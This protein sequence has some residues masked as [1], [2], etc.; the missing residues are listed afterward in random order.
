MR[1]VVIM[2]L[3]AVLGEEVMEKLAAGPYGTGDPM[4]AGFSKKPTARKGT[5][6]YLEQSL[7][8]QQ[9][10]GRAQYVDPQAAKEP[11]PKETAVRQAEREV[12]T[13]QQMAAPPEKGTTRMINNKPYQ[14]NREGSRWVRAGVPS[15]LAANYPQIPTGTL[16][17][18]GQAGLKSESAPPP[19]KPGPVSFSSLAEQAKKDYGR[20]REG[21]AGLPAAAGKDITGTG[22]YEVAPKGTGIVNKG[23]LRKAS[24]AERLQLKDTQRSALAD[25]GIAAGEATGELTPSQV[26]KARNVERGVLP[27]LGQ[28]ASIWTMGAAPGLLRGAKS[29]VSPEARATLSRVNKTLNKVTPRAGANIQQV[30]PPHRV[31]NVTTKDIDTLRWNEAYPASIRADREMRDRVVKRLTREPHNVGTVVDPAAAQAEK[32]MGRAQAAQM[33]KRLQT[34]MQ[35]ARQAKIQERAW[36]DPKGREPARIRE[37]HNIYRGEHPKM[38]WARDKAKAQEQAARV[39]EYEAGV[40]ARKAKMKVPVETPPKAPVNTEAQEAARRLQAE[41]ESVVPGKTGP[42]K[43]P[44]PQAA[45]EPASKPAPEPASRPASEAAPK[46]VAEPAPK[47]QTTDE[48]LANQR[49][50]AANRGLT[51]EQLKRK[52]QARVDAESYVGARQRYSELR[53]GSRIEKPTWGQRIKQRTLHPRTDPASPEV[54]SQAKGE[55]QTARD[56]LRKHPFRARSGALWDAIPN[57]KSRIAK[58]LVRNTARAGVVAGGAEVVGTMRER[59]F[60]ANPEGKRSWGTRPLSTALHGVPVVG[61]TIGPWA[62]KALQGTSKSWAQAGKDLVQTRGSARKQKN[63]GMAAEPGPPGSGRGINEHIKPPTPHKGLTT[64]VGKGNV[65]ALAPGQEKQIAAFK[66]TPAP[67]AAPKYKPAPTNFAEVR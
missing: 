18:Q 24:P 1:P 51:E 2:R 41:A 65:S 64:V 33:R 20:V 16:A 60:G 31:G 21:L 10:K 3:K 17:A 62:Q 30:S 34:R 23:E 28:T 11:T 36:K 7:L 43:A 8:E 54:V 40:A 63:F 19:G 55:A 46:P 22:F 48:A 47:P 42:T 14:L 37:E 50:A 57:K 59:E 38:Q 67:K 66:G 4:A 5:D 39:P 49:Q 13:A 9:Q 26:D 56:A 29:L 27:T 45:P 15:H 25:L 12:G 53:R 6:A 61:S 35:E 32:E 44:K 58:G 52:A